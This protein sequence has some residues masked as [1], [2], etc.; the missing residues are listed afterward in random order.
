MTA[1]P[2]DR[3][4]NTVYKDSFGFHIQMCVNR[5]V[6]I[7]SARSNRIYS[8]AVSLRLR[9]TLIVPLQYFLP[10]RYDWILERDINHVVRPYSHFSSSA[11]SRGS[12]EGGFAGRANA[13]IPR[14]SLRPNFRIAVIADEGRNGEGERDGGGERKEKAGLINWNIPFQQLNRETTAARYRKQNGSLR[15]GFPAR[16]PGRRRIYSRCISLH[17]RYR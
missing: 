9:C 15:R 14:D 17:A 4:T 13:E 10:R 12:I 7:S 2:K 1:R 6:S 5:D 11:C 16:F 3:A 8:K